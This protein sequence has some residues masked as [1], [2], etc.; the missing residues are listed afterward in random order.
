[1]SPDGKALSSGAPARIGNCKEQ[2]SATKRMTFT[3]RMKPQDSEQISR[4]HGLIT[5]KPVTDEFFT[6]L[7][8]HVADVDSAC[9]VAEFE[10]MIV[11]FAI[12]RILSLS[13]EQGKSAW[14]AAMDVDPSF[15]EQEIGVELA[16][17][18]LRHYERLGISAVQTSIRWNDGGRLSFF[19][20]LGFER[21]EFMC[22]VK[23]PN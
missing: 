15:V 9:F 13:P 18:I 22:L 10:G 4:L 7:A 23:K 17:E 3:R 6:L 14:I 20:N 16:G 12:A 5:G 8:V 1:M 19:R 2:M 11:G 21:S